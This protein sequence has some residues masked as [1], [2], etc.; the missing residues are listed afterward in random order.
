MSKPEYIFKYTPKNGKMIF[1]NLFDVERHCIEKDGIPQIA[2]I[3]DEAKLS[4]KEK[5]FAYLFGPLAN[6]AMRAYTFAGWDG[7]DKVKAVYLMQAEFCKEQTYNKNTKEVRVVLSSLS[8]MSKA[9]LLK[10]IQDCIFF[11]ETE[12]KQQVPDSET[13]KAMKYNEG[14]VST[15]FKEPVQC[16]VSPC[17]Y[18]GMSFPERELFNTYDSSINKSVKVCS[19]CSG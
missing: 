15:K 8:A 14:F 1:D 6:C 5:M 19:E 16:S 17:D 9:R 18:C 4:E 11:L 7:I 3:R 2:E 10:F 12:L 13:Y